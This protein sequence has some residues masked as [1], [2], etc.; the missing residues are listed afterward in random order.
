MT[1]A[2]AISLGLHRQRIR[3]LALRDFFVKAMRIVIKQRM[4][5]ARAEIERGRERLSLE[6]TRN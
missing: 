4:A 5:A 1:F 3:A 2:S 6:K